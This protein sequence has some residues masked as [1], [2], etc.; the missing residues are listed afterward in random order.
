MAGACLCCAHFFGIFRAIFHALSSGSVC[1]TLHYSRYS[2]FAIPYAQKK[3]HTKYFL[4]L[5]CIQ[6]NEQIQKHR[7]GKILWLIILITLFIYYDRN[8]SCGNKILRSRYELQAHAII[9]FAKL[10]PYTSIFLVLP[11][12]HQAAF[13]QLSPRF[14]AIYTFHTKRQTHFRLAL[15]RSEL[16][17]QRFPHEIAA[18]T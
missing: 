14:G 6:S 13:A 8:F 18:D 2:C 12:L 17:P 11:R 3:K 5:F 16:K 10:H 9:L 4:R 15:V 1:C 7:R